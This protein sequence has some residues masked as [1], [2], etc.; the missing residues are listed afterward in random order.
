MHPRRQELWQELERA[1]FARGALAPYGATWL[2]RDCA[3][4]VASA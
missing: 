3:P 1:V 4:A 2:G